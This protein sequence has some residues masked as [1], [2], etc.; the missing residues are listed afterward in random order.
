MQGIRVL[1]GYVRQ[2]LLC[3]H[4]VVHFVNLNTEV[5]VNPDFPYI[6]IENLL[7]NKNLKFVLIK[8]KPHLMWQ[9]CMP[10]KSYLK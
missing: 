5:Y 6:L 4:A 9:L 10:T 1:Y 3:K 2:D 7:K 8:K